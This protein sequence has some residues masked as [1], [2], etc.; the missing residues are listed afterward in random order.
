MY[1]MRDEKIAT[2]GATTDADDKVEGALEELLAG[3]DEFDAEIGM[4]SEIP[5][6][7][8]LMSLEVSGGMATIDLSAEFES[9]GGSLSMQARVAQVVFTV[10]QFDDVDTVS[11]QID[12]ADVES[13]GGE[14]IPATEVDRTD[15]TNVTPNILV[16]SPLPG[17]DVM[18]P[19][20]VSGMS[21]TFEANVEYSVTD[22]EGL[23]IEEGFTT[24]TAGNGTWGEFEFTVE[25]STDR[26]GLGAVIVFQ[27]SAET[28]EQADVYEVPVQMG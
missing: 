10:T 20:T 16:E 19:V 28:G 15:F 8:E 4:S 14:G 7:T 13:I 2:G 3:P 9:G 11:F 12:G 23:I 6:G 17:S 27:T 21:N 25:F 18:S 5:D 24:A 22:P 26:T 1:F